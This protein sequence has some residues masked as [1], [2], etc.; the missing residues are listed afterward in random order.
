MDP[1][2]AKIIDTK[3]PK[4]NRNTADGLATKHLAYAEQH[5]DSLLRSIAVHFPPNLVYE[6][7][8][9]VTPLEEYRETT[10]RKN[11]SN[12]GTSCIYNTARSDTYLVAL[13]LRFQGELIT[14]YLTLPFI[15]KQGF[16]HLSGVRYVVSPV[17]CDKIISISNS[18]VFVKLNL[19]KS[20]FKALPQYYL[21]NQEREV[22]QLVYSDNLYNRT[23]DNKKLPRSVV[24]KIP[25]SLYLFCKHGFTEAFKKYVGVIPIV[26]TEDEVNSTKYPSD[27]WIICESVGL[28]PIGLKL[29]KSETYK[30]SPIRLAFRR[31]DYTAKLRNHLVAFFYLLDHWPSRLKLDT[32]EYPNV[33]RQVLGELIRGDSESLGKLEVAANDHLDSL[34]KYIDEIMKHRFE[35]RG[36]PVEDMYELLG[37]I[38]ENFTQ[39]TLNIGDD[40]A[41]TYNKELDVLYYVLQDVAKGINNFHFR[42]KAELNKSGGKSLNIKELNT[43]LSNTIRPG[44]IFQLTSS[45]KHV[46]ISTISSSSDNRAF[47][48]TAMI[49]PQEATGG[50]SDK[51]AVTNPTQFLHASVAEVNAYSAINKKDPSGHNRINHCLEI[52]NLGNVVRNPRFIPLLDRVQKVL[53]RSR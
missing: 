12:G 41:S 24:A 30:A 53:N 11:N 3:M 17:L 48:T 25:S 20:V 52:D 2:L 33:W 50:N 13:Q 21:A 45:S 37:I 47:K 4:L 26:G 34:D 51:M 42:L 10:R 5:V 40:I 23:A 44:A 38:V 22:V 39:W 31:S 32:I 28:K 46:E 9:R 6:G 43:L 49:V 16:L 35:L 7:I 27:D 14:K 19:G 15:N 1:M 8:R 29:L 36:T 18:D